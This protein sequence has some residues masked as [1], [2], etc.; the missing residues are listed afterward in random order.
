MM[1]KV[2]EQKELTEQHTYHGMKR[3]KEKVSRGEVER[4]QGAP[5]SASIMWQYSNRQ[6]GGNPICIE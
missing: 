3:K 4:Y 2:K 5:A 6:Y 1:E